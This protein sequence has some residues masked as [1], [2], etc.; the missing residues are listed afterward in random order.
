MTDPP[1]LDPDVG[2]CSVCQ[3][4]RPVTSGRGSRFWLCER[5]AD[6]DRLRKY[7]ALPRTSCHAFVLSARAVIFPE[8]EAAAYTETTMTLTRSDFAAR[9]PTNDL[10][11]DGT[12]IVFRPMTSVDRDAI[13]A[14]ARALPE[15][16]L[17]FL[18]EDI[19]D[20]AVVDEWMGEISNGGTFTVLAE[21]GDIVVG[22]ASLR[23]E[24]ARWTR[25]VG[26]IRINVHSDYRGTGVGAALAGEIR[27]VAPALDVRKLSAQM[28]VDQSTARVV[29]ERLG[30]HEQAILS[31]WVSDRAGQ[32]RDLLIMVC[33]LPAK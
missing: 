21:V 23:T 5:A 15:D 31:G 22:Y 2:L 29:F 10:L 26:E 27:H 9:Y 17:L 33:D 18:R 4:G 25:H 11:N 30:F 8:P 28:T 19:T 6:D 13:L 16:D 7:P 14:F 3:H 1:A 12:A 24:P 20:P 32:E